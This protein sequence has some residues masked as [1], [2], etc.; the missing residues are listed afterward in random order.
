MWWLYINQYTYSRVLWAASF[1]LPVRL[2]IRPSALVFEISCLLS[3]YPTPSRGESLRP[4]CNG[5]DAAAGDVTL[6][7]R[8]LRQAV[9]YVTLYLPLFTLTLLP[10]TPLPP[11]T[12]HPSFLNRHLSFFFW[13]YLFFSSFHFS[14]SSTS[15]YL[16]S[17][18]VRMTYSSTY[19]EVSSV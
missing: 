16:P 15:L 19:T 4:C 2:S 12:A 9:A 13:F 7:D 18:F 5:G 17:S 3:H 14:H 10:F 1:C 11:R 6:K 8:A